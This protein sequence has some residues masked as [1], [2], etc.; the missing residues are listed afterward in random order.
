MH[1]PGFLVLSGDDFTW[2]P[3][4]T[5]LTDLVQAYAG[6]TPHAMLASSIDTDQTQNFGILE[7]KDG[8]L[9]RI[10]EKPQPG[11]TEARQINI[12]KYAFSA[13]ILDYLETYMQTDRTEEYYLTDV[14]QMAVN[15]GE[16]LRVIPIKGQYLD[17]GNEEGWLHANNVILGQ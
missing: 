9:N 3:G 6:G 1:E 14:F 17:G 13:S 10:L 2:Q 12:S 5:D 15:A 8:L 7:T 16:S 11:T 4:A